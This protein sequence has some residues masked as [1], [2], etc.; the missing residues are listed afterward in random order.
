MHAAR[1]TVG[2]LA[3]A[4]LWSGVLGG[5]LLAA[6]PEVSAL[7][8]AGGQRGATVEVTLGGKHETWPVQSWVNEPGLAITPGE[9]GKLSI[10]IAADAKPGLRWIRLFDAAGT[11]AP[12]PF[13]V[14]TLPE[15]V[16]SEGNNAPRTAQVLPSANV[17]VN[18]KLAPG[19]DVDVFRV[20][21]A[22]GQTLVAS[23]VGNGTLGSPMDTVLHVLSADGHQLA[24]NHDGRSLDPEIVFV[25]PTAGEYLLRVFGF[26]S[27]PNSTIGFSGSE[28]HLYRLSVATGGFADYAWPL[29]VSAGSPTSV[30]LVGWNLSERLASVSVE[31]VGEEIEIWDAELA[32]LARVRVEPHATLVEAEPNTL[33]APQAVT[34]PVTITGRIGDALDKDTYSFEAKAAQPLELVLES[35]TL[36]YPLDGTLEVF[37]ATGKRLVRIDDAGGGRDPSTVF[38]PPADGVYRVSVADL[39]TFGSERHVYRLRIV[40]TTPSFEVTADALAYTVAPDKPTEITLAIDRRHGFAE[41]LD[42]EVTG[43]PDFVKAAPAQSLAEGDTAKTVK[44]SLTS[45]GGEFSGPIR[46]QAKSASGT[47]RPA[48]AAIPAQTAQ[49]ADLWLT[50]AA[51]KP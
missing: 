7:F 41:V 35:R 24:Y 18:G 50:A 17:V 45:T 48:V 36:G 25:A 11:S 19:G 44:L 6:G 3:S 46:I 28:R 9:K 1:R 12:Q 16:E 39:N 32:N 42:L 37:D 27:Q 31:P 14:G 34:L 47:V 21:L 10:A 49:L 33:D 43:L 13:V 2:L 23:L 51:A 38:T 4:V 5:Q 26:P 20:T 8:P 22:A 30:A 40:P 15:F 29:A